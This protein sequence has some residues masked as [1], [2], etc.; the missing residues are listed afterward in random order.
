MIL[1]HGFLTDRIHQHHV[2]TIDEPGRIFELFAFH[3]LS[4]LKEE[5]CPLRREGTL[6][7][8]SGNQRI[9]RVQFKN[10]FRFG[11]ILAG[12]LHHADKSGIQ[13]V[14]IRHDAGRRISQAQGHTNVFDAVAQ[15]GFEF[16]DKRFVFGL[17]LF[18]FLLFFLVCQ[19]A[20][21]KIAFSEIDELLALE[22]RQELHHPAV[23]RTVKQQDFDI[24]FLEEL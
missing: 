11:N 17:N 9:I 23:D 5:L 4:L 19:V 10:R 22:F 21:I 13:A 2:H 1:V 3:Q 8:Q 6:L 24:F 12:R 7:F 20:E 15:S 18:F 16:I 14:R